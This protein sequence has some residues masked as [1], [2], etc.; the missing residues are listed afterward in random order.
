MLIA[1]SRADASGLQLDDVR[2]FFSSVNRKGQEDLSI[3][4]VMQV[5]NNL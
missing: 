2:E 4:D 3:D 1:F 5:L